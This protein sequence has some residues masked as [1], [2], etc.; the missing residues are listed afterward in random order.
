MADSRQ[1]LKASRAHA[2]VGHLRERKQ[3]EDLGDDLLREVRAMSQ[4]LQSLPDQPFLRLCVFMRARF[5]AR[6]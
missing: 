6:V 4:V 3:R 5:C 2:Q 1:G